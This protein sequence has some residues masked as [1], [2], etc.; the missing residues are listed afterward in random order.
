M[1]TRGGG[2]EHGHRNNKASRLL[3]DV[4]NSSPSLQ[5]IS[6]ISLSLRFIYKARPLMASC[7]FRCFQ[8]KAK[9]Y[10]KVVVYA[11]ISKT[12]LLGSIDVRK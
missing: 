4:I 5:E 10:W 3:C 12:K 11:D 2:M 7:C 8:M 1:V 6:L 9:V